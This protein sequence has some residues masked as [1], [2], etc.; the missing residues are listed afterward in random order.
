MLEGPEFYS[1]LSPITGSFALLLGI[2]V[3]RKN[4]FMRTSTVFL[5]LMA[6][7]LL[8]GILDFLLMNAPNE[9]SAMI[10]ARALMF[11]MVII[12]GGYLYLSSLLPYER[13]SGWFNRHKRGY[14][15]IVVITALVPAIA[16][17]QMLLT[18][19]G[20][21]VPNSLAIYL[22]ALIVMAYVSL[23][24]YMLLI[25]SGHASKRVVTQQCALMAI[26]VAVPFVY[27][28]MMNVLEAVS[29]DTVPVLAPGFLV[30]NII[31]AY[32]VLR[33]DLFIISPV[34]EEK[35]STSIREGTQT[36]DIGSEN[37]ILIEEKRAE[38]SYAIFIRE[39]G[40]G[41]HGLLITRTHPDT[42]RE[43]LRLVQTPII[44]LASQPGSDRI[45]A[46]NLSILQHT[47]IE[48]S[49]RTDR[50][51]VMIDGLEYLISNNPVKG[52]LR[53]IYNIRDELM[54]TGNRII[55]PLDTET[56]DTAELALFERECAVLV[57]R[58]PFHERSMK[59]A[60]EEVVG[61]GSP[62]DHDHHGA[63]EGRAGTE[64]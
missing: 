37:M 28:L 33:H 58:P 45:E 2:Y 19:Y 11:M 27:G 34:E 17:D 59:T 4:P 29:M 47:I 7:V 51:I 16:V 50:G 46:T 32:G 35:V 39:L 41:C 24:V 42:I 48:F 31:F 3:Y 57:C 9:N 23:A 38:R 49:R 6:L 56:M 60:S 62:G 21:G 25:V 8:S 1:I 40:Q 43:Q 13:S 22:L 36:V 55:L 44:W 18:S 20:W 15:T 5:K 12:F 10:I 61:R 64:I 52:V 26:A 63:R 53:M 14:W 30:S 54:E